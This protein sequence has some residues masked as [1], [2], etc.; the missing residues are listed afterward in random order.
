M[1]AALREVIDSLVSGRFSRGE[2]KLFRT[3][4]DGLL[5]SDLYLPILC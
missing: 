2:R 3:L 1:N 4:T 5:Y